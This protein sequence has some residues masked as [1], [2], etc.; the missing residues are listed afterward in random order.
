MQAE[1]KYNLYMAITWRV[2]LPSDAVNRI[3]G[4]KRMTLDA[5]PSLCFF[6]SF[7]HVVTVLIMALAERVGE[8]KLLRAFAI[9]LAVK[10]FFHFH[11]ALKRDTFK[12]L[13]LCK[14]AL[15][16]SKRSLASQVQLYTSLC[17]VCLESS[18]YV[19]LSLSVC[20]PSPLGHL[21]SLSVSQSG[22]S[23]TK[24]CLMLFREKLHPLLVALSLACS[25]SQNSRLALTHVT[26]LHV[27]SRGDRHTVS[28]VLFQRQ[29][30]F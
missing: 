30:E 25:Y 17:N 26:R 19:S 21:T 15:I 13:Y 27:R 29:V 4:K 28:R 22:H 10:M 7:Y 24:K 3:E 16:A 9:S 14:C 23:V 1:T 2:K 18:C 11:L 20:L 8:N 6:F 5:F 12:C